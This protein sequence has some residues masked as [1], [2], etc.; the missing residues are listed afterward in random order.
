MGPNQS[1]LYFQLA[2]VT[3]K[4][5]PNAFEI[6]ATV[7]IIKWAKGHALRHTAR[8]INLPTHVHEDGF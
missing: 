7:P 2:L 8:F 5:G 3:A 6:L 4:L 1:A